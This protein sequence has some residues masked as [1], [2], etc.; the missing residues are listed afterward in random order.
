M[1]R[2]LIFILSLIS[3]TGCAAVFGHQDKLDDYE[4]QLRN[5]DCRFEKIDRH[6]SADPLLWALNGGALARQCGDFSL[7]NHYFDL[8]EII[9]K[10]HEQAL[11]ISSLG[12]SLNSILI[13][14]NVNDYQ[15]EN[16]EKI[17]MNVYKGL[18]FMSLGD[19]DNARIEFNRVLDRQ[20]RAAEFFEKEIE[21]AYQN[22]HQSQYSSKVIGSI[23]SDE[24]PSN[25]RGQLT[26]QVVYPN[27]INPFATYIS[28]LFF[29]L[30]Q[31]YDKAY[32]L[33]QQTAEMLPNNQYI[34]GDVA[35]A[36]D[37]QLRHQ[38]FVWLIYEDGQG[39]IKNAFTYH[40]PSYL[41]TSN[42]I[43]STISVPTIYQRSS[44]YPYLSIDQNKTEVITDMDSIIQQEFNK[45]MPTILTE[46]MLNMLAK[47]AIQYTLETELEQFGGKYWGFLY[48]LST[49]RADIRQWRAIPKNFQIARV[50]LNDKKIDIYTPNGQLLTQVQL[51]TLNTD[52]IIYIKSDIVDHYSIHIIQKNKNEDQ[53]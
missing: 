6:L 49:S 52:A 47:S 53:P 16:Y 48:Q 46:A 30:E 4:Q 40:F 19:T 7:S 12:Q 45:K 41:F 20:R 15:G 33:F 50:P 28:G 34:Q 17:M 39:M 2:N 35:L 36:G 27:F 24:H 38:S 37:E 44:A 29:Y 31:D 42:V 25:Y 18:N 26:P 8:A 23:D 43:T 10:Q 51:F 3:L 14:N 9:F 11:E 13:N 5:N 21:N 1:L 22:Y 32:S